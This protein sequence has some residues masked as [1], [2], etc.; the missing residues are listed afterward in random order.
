MNLVVGVSPGPRHTGVVLR[1]GVTLRGRVLVQR[2]DTDAPI[3]WYLG[4][5]VDAVTKLKNTAR[6]IVLGDIPNLVGNPAILA[7]A[8][9][10]DRESVEGG[11]AIAQVIGAIAGHWITTRITEPITTQPLTHYPDRLQGRGHD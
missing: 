8:D 10:L 11:Y 2:T 6:S 3:D 7:V 4:D 5:V 1:Q 9:P